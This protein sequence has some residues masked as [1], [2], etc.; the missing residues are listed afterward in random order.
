MLY[1]GV[2]PEAGRKVKEHDAF[3]YACERCLT[4]TEEEQETFL[5]LAKESSDML[6]FARFLVEW[7]YSGNWVNDTPGG[8]KTCYIIRFGDNSLRSFFG[9]YL[10]AL[11]SARE[12]AREKGMSFYVVN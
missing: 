9:T 4:G 6:D 2:G 1:T 8:G 3:S 12:E 10:E 5:A 7:F 11:E